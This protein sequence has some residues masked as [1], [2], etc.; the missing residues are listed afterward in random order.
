LCSAGA[1]STQANIA[2]H[3]LDKR[4]GFED[5]GVVLERPLWTC[6]GAVPEILRVI[7]LGLAQ[8]HFAVFG[9]NIIINGLWFY[10]RWILRMRV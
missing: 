9:K 10:E 6:I 1:I 5:A 2:V 8:Y 4:A 3:T 7:I